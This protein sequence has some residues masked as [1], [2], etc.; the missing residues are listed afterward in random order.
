M[1]AALLVIA[2]DGSCL[3][4]CELAQ[5]VKQ[6]YSDAQLKHATIQLYN[7]T[8]LS[9]LTVQHFVQ[10]PALRQKVTD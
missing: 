10:S 7:S 3:E 8:G 6:Y 5:H 1:F 4:K 2:A 9:Q